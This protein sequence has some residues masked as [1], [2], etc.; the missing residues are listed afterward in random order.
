[1]LTGIHQTGTWIRKQSG[2]KD[3]QQ[4][5]NIAVLDGVRAIAA[6]TVLDFHVNLMTRDTHI[7]N[8]ANPAH[9]LISAIALAGASGVTLFFVLSGFLLFMPYAKALLFEGGCPS[10]REFYLRRVLR[11]M[12]GYYFALFAMIFIIHPEYLH[13]DHWRQLGL[14]LT[15]FMDSTPQTFQQLNGP[16]W[17]LA[18]EWQFY[19]LLPWLAL[20]FA[21]IARRL[22][23]PSQSP[24]RRFK[25]LL[26][27]CVGLIIWG[28]TLRYLGDYLTQ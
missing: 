23:P 24:L 27:C 3:R 12:P 22:A 4:K 9:T 19:L 7:W 20:L 2:D 8:P 10:A 28:L 13:P 25:L 11:I 5:N 18:I 14:F 1:M 17:T 6:L 16:F 21:L 15:F 26:A